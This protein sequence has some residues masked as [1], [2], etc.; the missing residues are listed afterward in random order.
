M[1]EKQNDKRFMID[2]DYPDEIY[3]LREALTDALCTLQKV[4]EYAH[5]DSSLVLEVKEALEQAESTLQ[6]TDIY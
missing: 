2:I 3:H 6:R 1:L 5:M 4:Y